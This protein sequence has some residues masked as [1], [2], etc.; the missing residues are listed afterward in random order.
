MW[1][2]SPPV[3]ERE[4]TLSML[5]NRLCLRS[6]GVQNLSLHHGKLL[7][8]VVSLL[9]VESLVRDYTFDFGDQTFLLG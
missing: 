5:S 7:K 4:A 6:I 8:R 1:L 9:F 2:V 3:D